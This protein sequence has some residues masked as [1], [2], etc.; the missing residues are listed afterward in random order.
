MIFHVKHG[1]YVQ[2]GVDEVALYLYKSLEFRNFSW[3]WFHA[4]RDNTRIYGHYNVVYTEISG[5][6]KK[7]TLNLYQ[8]VLI[9]FLALFIWLLDEIRKITKLNNYFQKRMPKTLEAL[10]KYKYNPQ[11]FKK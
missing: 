8:C 10:N 2:I 1:T 7:V 5:V 4:W 3:S 9:D 11:G 6:M